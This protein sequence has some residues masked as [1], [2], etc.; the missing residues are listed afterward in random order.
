MD[1]N[2]MEAIEYGLSKLNLKYLKEGKR[3][4][5]DSQPGTTL[6]ML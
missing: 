2:F 3:N 4:A 6:T 1:I 5:V